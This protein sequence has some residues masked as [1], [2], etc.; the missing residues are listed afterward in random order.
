[1]TQTTGT[2]MNITTRNALDGSDVPAAIRALN[3]AG[4]SVTEIAFAVRVS[5]STVYRWRRGAGRPS[6]ANFD[7][8]VTVIGHCQTWMLARSD[9]REARTATA[10][11]Y[12]NAAMNAMETDAD[13]VQSDALAARINASLDAQMSPV[14]ARIAGTDPFALVRDNCEQEI[15][16]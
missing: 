12:V 15:P 8:L 10:L 6:L 5:R 16:F 14:P 9:I 2:G 11:A 13:R 3:S 1:M 4:H 7:K